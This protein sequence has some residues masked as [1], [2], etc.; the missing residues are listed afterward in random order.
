MNFQK[1]K[2]D[3]CD[4]IRSAL[5]KIDEKELKGFI[6]CMLK[7]RTV[8]V[9][10]VGRVMLMLKAFAKRIKHLGYD[11]WVVGET[12]IPA[13]KKGDILLAASGSGETLTTVDVARLA[14]KNG[15]TVAL[16]TASNK[17]TLREIS[18]VVIRIPSPTKLHMPDETSSDQ[19][20]TNLFEQSLLIFC[21]CLSIILQIE[22]K[23]TEEKMWEVH[24]NLE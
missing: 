8:F 10:G 11:S 6:E 9:I 20:M 14:K 19:P 2:D 18:D 4:E 7:S 15:A 21:D 22:L 13:I 12:T 16:I 23:V 1:L 24:A 17:S 5:G 3:V